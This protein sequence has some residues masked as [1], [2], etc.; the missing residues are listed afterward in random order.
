MLTKLPYFYLVKKKTAK[1]FSE[2]VLVCSFVVFL[3]FVFLISFLTFF[4]QEE[5]KMHLLSSKHAGECITND[6]GC[7][8]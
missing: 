4:I 8:I 7:S 3:C 6:N 2:G 1:L 5:R